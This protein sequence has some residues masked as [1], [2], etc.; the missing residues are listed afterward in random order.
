[1]KLWTGL[2]A[3]LGV[4]AVI[5]LAASAHAD[6]ANS[7]TTFLVELRDAGITYSNPTQVIAAG[8]GVCGMMTDGAQ[9]VQVVNEVASRNPGFT[10]DGAAVFTRLAATAY[11]P[12][13]LT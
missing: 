11:C 13:H 4:P 9:G 7:D 6:P 5:A 8:R 10:L 3:A 12:Q 2:V 1:M